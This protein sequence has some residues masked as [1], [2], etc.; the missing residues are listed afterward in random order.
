M[1]ALRE[2]FWGVWPNAGGG[3]ASATATASAV[4]VLSLPTAGG[5]GKLKLYPDQTEPA[6]EEFWE[7]REEYLRRVHS[8]AEEVIPHAIVSERTRNLNPDDDRGQEFAMLVANRE[9]AYQA[10]R[11]AETQQELEGHAA[12]ITKLTLQLAQIEATR[13]LDDEVILLLLL[14]E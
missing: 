14:T 12:V 7:V 4:V 5:G 6:L 1:L 13:Q 11:I 10:A 8:V 3:S 9:R 2:F